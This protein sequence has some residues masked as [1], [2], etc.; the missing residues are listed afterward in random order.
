V[1][2]QVQLSEF[3]SQVIKQSSDAAEQLERLRN[4]VLETL[5]NTLR[6]V[7]SPAYQDPGTDGT[8]PDPAGNDI[9]DQLQLLRAIRESLDSLLKGRTGPSPEIRIL[10]QLYFGS[11]HRREDD[12]APAEVDTFEWILAGPAAKHP[13]V[14]EHSDEEEKHESPQREAAS[15]RFLHWLREENGV[16]HISGK[17][18]SGKSTMMKLLLGDGRTKQELEKWAGTSQLVFAHFFF[19]LSG[20]RLQYSLEGLH[21]SILF[22]ALIRCPE[23]IPHVF[24]RAYK[25]FSKGNAVESIDQ[26]FFS[27]SDIKN[28]FTDLTKGSPLPGYRLCLFID[29]LDEYGG[30]DVDELEH[31]RL[32]DALNSWAAHPDVKILASSRPHRQFEDTFSDERRIR[33]HELTRSD[34]VLTGR[35]MFEKDKSFGRPE[36]Q[37]CYADLVEKVADASDGVFLWAGLAIRSLLNAIGRYDPIDSLEQHLHGIPRNV[38]KLYEKMFKSI[39]LVDRA[40]AFKL[41]LLVAGAPNYSMYMGRLNALSVTWLQDLEQDDFPMKCGFQPYS[42][43]DIQRRLLE[44]QYQVDSLTRGLLEI[45][46]SNRAPL[47][48][49][50]RVQFFH[51]TVRDFVGQST[52][53]QEFA[54]T[55]PNLTDV[56]TYARL[57]LAELYFA[58]TDD[59]QFHPPEYQYAPVEYFSEDCHRDGLLD[60]YGLA[61]EQHNNESLVRPPVF[62]GFTTTL[63]ISPSGIWEGTSSFLHFLASHGVVG[64]VQRKVAADPGLLRPQERMSLL[65]SAAL[66]RGGPGMVKSLIEAGASSRHLVSTYTGTSQFTVWQ[67]VCTAVVC[68]LIDPSRRIDCLRRNCEIIQYFLEAGVDVNCFALLECASRISRANNETKSHTK[69][70]ADSQAGSQEGSQEGSQPKSDTDSPAESQA[71]SQ[72]GSP[73]PRRPTHAISMRTLLRQCNPPNLTELLELMEPPRQSGGTL[74]GVFHSA[75][76]YLVGKKAAAPTFRLEDYAPFDLAMDPYQST[77]DGSPLFVVSSVVFSGETQVDP[78]VEIKCW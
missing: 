22:E 60:A 8:F 7:H 1:A 31:Q 72:A 13:E 11:L 68:Q 48:R 66:G 12:M 35:Q 41:L 28:A 59:I 16:F 65:L 6:Q 15:A 36:V 42:K 33:L 73:V 71:A 23:L 77:A 40:R 57:Q 44:A 9:S 61:M 26:L 47:F 78:D 58:S 53:L 56:S 75:W 2:I 5:E 4:D 30:D 63:R 17:P 64:Y 18:G 74:L 70:Q 37:A 67:L 45:V 69:S 29:G 38:D 54:T 51:R 24:P 19:W 34:I 46:D 10:K 50:K 20:E 25:S 49:R 32:A 39:D 43:E 52:I 55:V 76:E 3:Q 14:R 62:R 27:S 21:R